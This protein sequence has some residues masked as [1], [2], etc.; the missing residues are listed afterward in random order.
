MPIGKFE[1]TYTYKLSP[2][3]KNK[4]DIGAKLKYLPP[5]LANP[6]LQFTIKKGEMASE[7]ASGT[8]TVDPK[9]GRI[10]EANLQI[11]LRG[12]LTLEI[13]TW[14]SEVELSQIRTTTVRTLD[15]DPTK[16]K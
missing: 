12:T 14:E 16:G 2:T 3:D 6:A 10:V 8:A 5:K 1:S 9:T 11:D 15:R 13:G 7:K 4:V